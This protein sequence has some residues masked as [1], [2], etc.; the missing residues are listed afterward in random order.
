MQ[1]LK[2]LAVKTRE[3]TNANGEKK[4]IWQTVGSIMRGND[5]NEFMTLEKWFNPAG[6]ESKDGRSSILI[7]MFEPRDER[8][9]GQQPSQAQTPKPAARNPLDDDIPF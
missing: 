4:A 1:K 3:Y 7:S 5:G 6:I 8:A 2:D 9:G